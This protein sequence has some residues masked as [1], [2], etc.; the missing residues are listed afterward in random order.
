[1]LGEISRLASV[2]CGAGSKLDTCI[3]YV[4]SLHIRDNVGYKHLATHVSQD[5]DP[6]GNS[7]KKRTSQNCFRLNTKAGTHHPR[8]QQVICVELVY[9]A[10]G[11]IHISPPRQL[12][13]LSLVYR[14]LAD[15]PTMSDRMKEFADIPRDF[16]KEGTQVGH[17]P[18]ATSG[19]DAVKT[20]SSGS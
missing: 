3:L 1:M 7:T 11:F 13:Y 19:R 5:S 14:L 17:L 6:A 4:A 9:I 15:T 12:S 2:P 10:L 18:C 20:R 16:V 8:I